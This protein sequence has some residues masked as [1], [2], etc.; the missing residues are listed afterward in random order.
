MNP[1]PSG[2]AAPGN[3]D[4][5]SRIAD[6]IAENQMLRQEIRVAREAANITADL[7]VKQFEASEALLT[8]VQLANAETQAVLDTAVHTAIIV[9]DLNGVIR[10]FS[11]GAERLLGYRAQEVIGKFTALHFHVPEEV[12]SLLRERGLSRD[13][14]EG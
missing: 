9:T 13:E 2:A 10:L 11:K 5:D 12:D 7:V 4:A 3:R 6:L 8:R 1:M 14:A